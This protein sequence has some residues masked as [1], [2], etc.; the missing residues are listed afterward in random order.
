MP[1]IGELSH[2]FHLAPLVPKLEAPSSPLTFQKNLEIGIVEY[3]VMV[4]FPGSY[5][6]AL[7]KGDDVSIYLGK[8][9]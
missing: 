5:N 6:R 3:I 2:G 1:C 8:S 4:G 7:S 9:H